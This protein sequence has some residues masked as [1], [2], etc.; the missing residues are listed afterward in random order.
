MK[1]VN[2]RSSTAEGTGDDHGAD[3]EQSPSTPPV[4]MTAAKKGR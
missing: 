4:A 3:D 1:V 2:G